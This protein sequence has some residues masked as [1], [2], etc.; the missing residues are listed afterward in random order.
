[1]TY[2]KYFVL[3]TKKTWKSFPENIRVNTDSVPDNKVDSKNSRISKSSSKEKSLSNKIPVSPEDLL[4]KPQVSHELTASDITEKQS[5]TAQKNV[6][7][8]EIDDFEPDETIAEE[9]NFDLGSDLVV[10]ERFQSETWFA[11]EVHSYI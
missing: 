9:K 7:N 3:K 11:S 1:M 5:A 8:V 4:K 2:L 10:D 6:K